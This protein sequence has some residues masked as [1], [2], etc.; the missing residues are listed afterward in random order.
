[1]PNSTSRRAKIRKIKVATLFGML[2]RTGSRRRGQHPKQHGCVRAKFEV[3]ADIPAEYKVG[4][5]AKPATYD[6]LV[7]F[8]NGPQPKDSDRGAQGMAIKLIGVPGTK[9]LSD[10]NDAPTHDFI[11]VDGPVFFVRDIDWY[12]R[13]VS[14]LVRLPEGRHPE[15]WLADLKR[16][17]KDDIAVVDEYHRPSVLESGAVCLRRRR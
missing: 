8:S 14:E 16:A 13:L 15:K 3:L 5:F 11:L 6:A 7:R 9:I 1:M 4:L 2:I 17:H 12:L 10:Q